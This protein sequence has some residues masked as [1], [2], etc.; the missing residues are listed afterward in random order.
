MALIFRRRKAK[1]YYDLYS[2]E[3]K[4]QTPTNLMKFIYIGSQH[5]SQ[6]DARK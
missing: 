3:S 6:D 1:N 4:W 2:N 5:I